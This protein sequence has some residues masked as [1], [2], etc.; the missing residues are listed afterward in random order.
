MRLEK[1]KSLEQA[2]D[3]LQIDNEALLEI[4]SE[5]PKSYGELVELQDTQEQNLSI[6][7]SMEIRIEERKLETAEIISNETVINPKLS[8]DQRSAKS[9]LN[10]IIKRVVYEESYEKQKPSRD[11]NQRSNSLSDAD[12]GYSLFEPTEIDTNLYLNA[13]RQYRQ[14]RRKI[15]RR[16]E[17]EYRH[18]L[19]CLS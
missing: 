2:K 10:E 15:A 9:T 4:E 1:E 19:E 3:L 14:S 6:S 8:D 7:N 11:H 13:N 18:L 17:L 16:N 12:K 5:I